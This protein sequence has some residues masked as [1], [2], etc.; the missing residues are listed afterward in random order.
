MIKP[1]II[2]DLCGGTGSWSKPY[3]EP[4]YFGDNHSKKT[5]LWGFFEHPKQIFF[6]KTEVMREEDIK[7]CKINN[8]ILPSVKG[9]S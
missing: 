6:N 9:L 4:W 3:F 7:R 1:K 5:G 2:L 8:R